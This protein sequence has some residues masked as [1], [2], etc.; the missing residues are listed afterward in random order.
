MTTRY[1]HGTLRGTGVTDASL[2]SFGAMTSHEQLERVGR[3]APAASGSQEE[4]G[5]RRLTWAR[6]ASE[7][8]FWRC[9][10]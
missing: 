1:T 3:L 8:P 4:N 10:S 7:R 2:V 5:G 6:T 9:P